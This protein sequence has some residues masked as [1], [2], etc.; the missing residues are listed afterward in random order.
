MGNRPP[1]L[2]TA[3]RGR[4]AGLIG[5]IVV[6]NADRN[7]GGGTVTYMSLCERERETRLDVD[8]EHTACT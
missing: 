2:P 1:H 4:T 5:A 8:G 7:A 6:L 3:G